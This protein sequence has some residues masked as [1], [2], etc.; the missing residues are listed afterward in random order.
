MK[1]GKRASTWAC[2]DP[3]VRRTTASSCC[4]PGTDSSISPSLSISTNRDM[5]VPRASCGRW[6]Y[7]LKVATVCCTLPPRPAT[8]SGWRMSL[9]PTLSMAMRRVSAAPCTS[10]MEAALFLAG[11]S[12]FFAVAYAGPFGLPQGDRADPGARAIQHARQFR[13]EMGRD[14][15][16]RGIDLVERRD[17][18]ERGGDHFDFDLP[19]VAVQTAAFTWIIAEQMGGGE[20][21]DH[22]QCVTGRHSGVLE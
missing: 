9:M 18:V 11:S 19:V 1:Q 15:L 7:M 21:G 10:A 12:L 16:R 17:V 8:R 14:I 20:I 2:S 3:S 22:L 5:C 6:T 13:V 4:M